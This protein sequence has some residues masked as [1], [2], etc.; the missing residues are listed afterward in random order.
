MSFS[1]FGVVSF[2]V[3]IICTV[4]LILHFRVMKKRG[5]MD[6]ALVLV[7]ERMFERLEIILDLM[8]NKEE[9]TEETEPDQAIEDAYTLCEQLIHSDIHKMIKT[10]PKIKKVLLTNEL[11]NLKIMTDNFTKIELAIRSYNKRLTTFNSCISRFP[12]KI[13]AVAVGFKPERELE[14][15]HMTN[16]LNIP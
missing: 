9:Q 8:E 15:K 3:F 13:I 14:I 12:G 5:K 1:I 7:E 2:I 11:E 4:V 6:D 10:Y 16:P